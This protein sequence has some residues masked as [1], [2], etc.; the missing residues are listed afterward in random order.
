MDR[1]KL[2]TTLSNVIEEQELDCGIAIR[3][4]DGDIALTSPDADLNEIVLN[5][6]IVKQQMFIKRLYAV[7]PSF[8]QKKFFVSF[9]LK[10]LKEIKNDQMFVIRNIDVLNAIAN[11]KNEEEAKILADLLTAYAR[12]N[13]INHFNEPNTRTFRTNLNKNNNDTSN[14]NNTN[15]IPIIYL[16]L[17]RI[18]DTTYLKNMAFYLC[19][20]LLSDVVLITKSQPETIKD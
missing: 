11:A 14:N 20:I 15:R 7:L 5:T 3:K 8:F 19:D 9:E 16:V 13:R 10:M 6:D 12:N 18:N 2:I 4:E 17:I 1:A